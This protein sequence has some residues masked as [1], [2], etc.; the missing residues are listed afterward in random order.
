MLQELNAWDVQPKMSC[1]PAIH[2]AR[3]NPS[4]HFHLISVHF[5]VVA[6]P[7]VLYSKAMYKE[8]KVSPASLSPKNVGGSGSGK[9]CRMY[10]S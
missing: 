3:S 6:P 4:T 8:R 2:N 10:G 1:L 7:N 9:F 5:R